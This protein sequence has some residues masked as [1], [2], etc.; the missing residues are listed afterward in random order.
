M[1]VPTLSYTDTDGQHTVKLETAATTLG[2]S[3]GQN[4]ILL[5]PFVSRQHAVIVAENSTYTVMDRDSSHGTFLNG[6][7]VLKAVLKSGDVLQLGSL[8]AP[9]LNFLFDG[10]G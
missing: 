8:E 4:I 7:R 5:D 1:A 10:A 2:R 6:E 9:R 3:P